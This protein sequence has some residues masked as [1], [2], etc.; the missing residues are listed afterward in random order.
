MDALAGFL[1][2]PRARGA[3]VLRTTFSSPF[4]IRLEDESPLTLVA[5]VRGT[6]WVAGDGG[7]WV[8][9]DAGDVGV[10]RGPGHYTMA[11]DPA[12][13][14]QVVVK[15]GQQCYPIGIP[16]AYPIDLGVRTWGTDPDGPIST[17][18]G[19]YEQPGAVSQRLLD[20]LPPLFTLSA[21]ELASPL[22]GLLAT[23]VGRDDPGQ[24]AV[25]DRLLDLLVITV[26]RTWFDRTAAPAW[27]SAHRDPL[28]GRALRRLHDEPARPWTVASLAADVGV[29]RAAL[30][31]RFTEAVGEPPM[32]YLAG[33]RLA[34][35][36][37]LLREP[38]ATVAGVARQVGYASPYALSTAFKRVRGVSPREHR[39]MSPA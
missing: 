14:P 32:S 8:R 36:A 20:A 4:A 23:E 39:T 21:A 12:S 25:L 18:C 15:P 3:F 13:P 7:P 2:G 37:D 29:S 10:A 17:V 34:L 11:D 22:V 38:D 35:A 31:R 19:A 5:V 9:L 30:A 27:Y 28:V 24:E 1:D 16:D 26:L 33:W 6:V